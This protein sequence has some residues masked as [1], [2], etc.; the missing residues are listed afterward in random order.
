MIQKYKRITKADILALDLN[1]IS[2]LKKSELK[3]YIQSGTDIITKRN[4]RI[5]AYLSNKGYKQTLARFNEEKY[6]ITYL[7]YNKVD[8]INTLRHKLKT[9]K[10]N[11]LAKGT[12]VEGQEKILKNFSKRIAE[13]KLKNE[14]LS[15]EEKDR[16]IKENTKKIRE[17]LT[18]ENINDFWGIYNDV[19]QKAINAH[20]S[21]TQLQKDI[22]DLYIEKNMN[23][24]NVEDLLSGLSDN[25]YIKKEL[26]ENKNYGGLDLKS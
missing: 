11:L 17:S 26:E 4:K 21:S 19:K 5:E 2:K 6:D 22:Y 13:L 8:G 20:Y 23:K 1:D 10:D 7:I 15:T 9:I 16:L 25:T 3:A 18:D 12:T 24:V 14:K